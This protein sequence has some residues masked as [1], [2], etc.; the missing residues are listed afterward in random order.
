[1]SISDPKD[2]LPALKRAKASG[3]PAVL[4]VKTKF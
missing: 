3:L 1:E 4:D 2:I